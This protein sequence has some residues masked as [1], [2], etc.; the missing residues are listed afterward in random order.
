MPSILEGERGFSFLLAALFP[1]AF[2]DARPRAR[3]RKGISHSMESFEESR[4]FGREWE[5]T[6]MTKILPAD[7]LASFF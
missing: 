3:T 4:W 7:H 5:N 2:R 6:E 1:S